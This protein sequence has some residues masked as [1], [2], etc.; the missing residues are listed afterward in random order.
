M[1]IPF[2]KNEFMI[3]SIE[4]KEMEKTEI[5]IS[6]EIKLKKITTAKIMLYEVVFESEILT[7]FPY[8]YRIHRENARWYMNL[9]KYAA[10][11]INQFHQIALEINVRNVN[12]ICIFYV[13]FWPRHS[14]SFINLFALAMLMRNPFICCMK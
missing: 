2:Y 13:Y 5:L 14:I 11:H 10:N 9:Y 8:W 12:F 7:D 1:E 4:W 6:F 3:C